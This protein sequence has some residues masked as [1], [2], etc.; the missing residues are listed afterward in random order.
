MI[1]MQNSLAFVITQTRVTTFS[2]LQA[3]VDTQQP[4]PANGNAATLSLMPGLALLPGQFAPGLAEIPSNEPN[5]IDPPA[6]G[7]PDAV[8]DKQH[9]VGSS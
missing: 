3:H 1:N 5:K 6:W 2:Y 7:L 8:Q 4:F 9:P